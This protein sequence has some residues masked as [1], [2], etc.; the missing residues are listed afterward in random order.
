MTNLYGS[1][2]SLNALVQV[3][4]GTALADAVD[5]LDLVWA[6]GGDSSWQWQTNTTHDGVDA[7]WSGTFTQGGTAWIETT[8]AG[9]VAVSFWWKLASSFGILNLAVDGTDWASL[10]GSANWR[11]RSF[12][13]PSGIHSFRWAL[14]ARAMWTANAWLDQVTLTSPA[15]PVITSQ[16][17]SYVG[18][19][20]ANAK[21]SVAVVGTEPFSYQW[22]QDNVAIAG[23]TSTALTITNV[24]PSNTSG[25]RVVVTNVAGAATSQVATITVNSSAP[26]ITAGPKS[27]VIAPGLT[28][29]F[30]SAVNGTQP[31]AISWQFNRS[32]LP[33]AMNASLFITNVQPSD[34][35]LYRVVANNELGTTFSAEAAL[36][37]V[38][39]TAWGDNSWG[40]TQVPANVGDVVAVAGGYQHSLALRRDGTVVY[41]GSYSR[42][43]LSTTSVCCRTEAQRCGVVATWTFL[44]I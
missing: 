35:G 18:L 26:V 23:A 36:A 19:A 29:S 12:F 10:S 16:P 31:M 44:A 25:Y 28:A 8:V 7:A 13:V 3:L 22:Q 37:L 17:A 1:A 42:Q 20:G 32:A 6:T 5:A 24:Q 9:P 4:P 41:W 38:P 11:Q 43:P 2:A 40:Q 34:A 33:G 39:V 21:F 15:V 14:T 27:L 30:D